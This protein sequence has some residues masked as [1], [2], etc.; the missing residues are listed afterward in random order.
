MNWR[1]RIARI[2]GW[3]LPARVTR[4]AVLR[5]MHDKRERLTQRQASRMQLRELFSDIDSLV[6][7]KVKK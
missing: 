7:F 3:Y 2:V 1:E 5:V 4:W 6:P